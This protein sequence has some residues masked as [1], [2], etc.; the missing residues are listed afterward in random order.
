MGGWQIQHQSE[1]ITRLK[2]EVQQWRNQLMRLEATTRREIQDWKDQYLRAEDERCHLSSRVDEL[3]AEHMAVCLYITMY[4]SIDP[5]S[6]PSS[7]RRIL[8]VNPSDSL[9]ES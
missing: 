6:T 2:E 5:Y 9:Q 7:R 1:T 3:L 8:T 4:W